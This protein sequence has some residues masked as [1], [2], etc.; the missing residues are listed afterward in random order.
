MTT[1][2][3]LILTLSGQTDAGQKGEPVPPKA[4]QIPVTSTI[5]GVT[6]VD[7]FDWMRK[8]DCAGEA[9]CQQHASDVERYLIEENLYSDA[10][11]Q[12]HQKLRTQV[13]QELLARIQPND[14][15]APY[16]MRG[17]RYFTRTQENQEH[18]VYVR[19]KLPAGAEEILIDL[20]ELGQKNQFVDLSDFEISD[21]NSL[22]AT[23]IDVTGFRENT[24]SVK[25]LNTNKVILKSIPHVVSMAFAA[26][27]KTIFYTLEDAA[28]RSA[29][30]MRHAL[31]KAQKDVLVFDEKDERFEVEISRTL[32]QKYLVLSLE[33]Q[34][35]SEEYLLEAIQP[36]GKFNLVLKRKQGVKYSLSHRSNSLF[37][38]TNQD[39]RTNKLVEVSLKN[40]TN[41]TGEVAPCRENRSLESAD[42]FETFIVLTERKEGHLAMRSIDLASGK[43]SEFQFPESDFYVSQRANAEF[44]TSVYQYEYTSLVSPWSV[45]ERNMKTGVT[46]LKKR[47]PVPTYLP[48]K[49]ESIRVWATA[50]D[51]AK[52]PISMVFRKGLALTGINP[53]YLRGYGAYGDSEESVFNSKIVSLLDRGVIF[54]HAHVRGGGEFG[55]PWHDGGR[56]EKK[57]NTF[58]DFIAC[59]ETLIAQRY[60]SAAKL[61]IGGAS[62]G[63]LLMG[64]VLN[65]RPELFKAAWV[66]VPFV[67]VINTMLDE[68]IPLTVGEFEEWGNPKIKNEFE[69][70]LAYS[71]YDNVKNQ[72]HPAILVTSSI[73]DSQVLFHEPTK[74][75]AKMRAVRTDSAPLLLKM[76]M[77]PAGHFG[78][79]G[80]FEQ[81][82]DDAF[83]LAF[84]LSQLGATELLK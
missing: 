30:L 10:V 12:P 40:P 32:S 21:D 1:I 19:Q 80:R 78:R 13:G 62:A 50:K 41:I 27:N 8:R 29:K 74:W 46:E 20:N 69:H 5:H 73:N 66:G 55:K 9:V 49:Y 68:S 31:G 63:G 37:V 76:Q 11:M 22:L 4:K 24:L 39:C 38:L 51:G 75:V 35:T 17:Y 14:T 28:K 52:I 61:A 81:A 7:N 3:A 2:L 15:S 82:A 53:L 58:D 33:S 16:E 84:L 57:Q 44:K 25:N 56:M 23:L 42:V 71:P 54:A 77:E 64:A 26:D 72:P 60:T 83:P 67:D 45:F 43:E 70:M 79:A 18:A 36:K 47:Q 59:A 65:Q 6:R 34:T 48:E